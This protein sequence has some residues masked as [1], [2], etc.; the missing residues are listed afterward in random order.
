MTSD[1]TSRLDWIHR[2]R[3]RA[4]GG[5][6][7]AAGRFP[8]TILALFGLAFTVSLAE[9]D[10]IA[11]DVAERLGAFFLVAAIASLLASVALMSGPGLWRRAFEVLVAAAMGA[12]AAYD[13]D[14]DYR[15]PML[16]LGLLLLVPAALARGS[17]H[18]LVPAMAGLG[19]AVALGLLTLLIFAGGLSG[20]LASLRY[21][22]GLPV[23]NRVFF[24][25]WIWTGLFFAPL[26]AL[27]RIPQPGAV[28]PAASRAL[29]DRAALALFDFG[30]I[31]LLVIYAMVLHSYAVSILVDSALPQGQIGWM[32]LTYA[33][34]FFGT[35]ILTDDAETTAARPPLTRLFFRWWPLLTL[36]PLGLLIVSLAERVGAYGITPERYILGLA[37]ATI[38]ATLLL[39]LRKGT[40]ND[41][42]I[43]L[44]IGG[45]VLLVGSGGPWGAQSVSIASQAARF[46]RE[47]ASA[48]DG[49]SEAQRQAVEALTYLSRSH[50]LENTVDVPLEVEGGQSKLQVYADHFSLDISVPRASQKAGWNDI[51]RTLVDLS[52]FDRMIG[53]VLL[54]GGD[55]VS[56]PIKADTPSDTLRLLLRGTELEIGV[57]EQTAA[58]PIAIGNEPI[59]TS[60]PLPES[61]MLRSD[62]RLI[63]LLIEQWSWQEDDESEAG[64]APQALATLRFTLLLRSSDWDALR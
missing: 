15:L 61:L 31:P 59:E 13:P 4:S 49:D 48:R 38:L 26:F 55:T 51:D 57:G 36:V 29:R 64:A 43:P 2:W 12:I 28:S 40:R 22:F 32:V 33:A 5:L 9:A 56:V 37:A 21:L 47:L 46:E 3:R 14:A 54:S 30:A 19:L 25:T 39:Q 62:G 7:R 1:G 63:R 16:V 52:E 24:Q 60:A 44:L 27:G 58:F 34:V 18:A 20:T 50:A 8:W 45:I 42:R 35:L 11:E 41:H 10:V 23:P 6:Q 53:G 17:R